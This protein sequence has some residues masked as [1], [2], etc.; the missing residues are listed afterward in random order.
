MMRRYAISVLLATGLVPTCLPAQETPATDTTPSPA[1]HLQ[2]PL[3]EYVQFLGNNFK[4]QASGVWHCK[5][6]R[7]T[8]L[9]VTAIGAAILKEDRRLNREMAMAQSQYALVRHTSPVITTLGGLHGIVLL[10]G[11]G[12]YSTLAHDHQLATTVMLASQSYITSGVWAIVLKNSFG[13]SRPDLYNHWTGP[14]RILRPADRFLSDCDE[15]NSF[16]SGHTT[17]AFSIATVFAKR[18]ARHPL[19]GVVAYSTAGLV[20]LSRMTENRHWGS[21]ILAGALLG[22]LCGNAVVKNYDRWLSKGKQTTIS[23]TLAR[24]NIYP[25]GNSFQVLYTL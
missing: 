18:Y 1:L 20:G 6:S 17:T 9:A 21:D 3:T 24:L 8:L 13:R 7:T 16:P 25:L 4:Y 19:V 2:R 12:V 22:Y 11:V 14:G 23:H 5:P 10:G 15:F